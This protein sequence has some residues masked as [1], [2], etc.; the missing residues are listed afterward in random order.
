MR[1]KLLKI[2]RKLPIRVR[3]SI[4]LIWISVFFWLPVVTA[5]V[6]GAVDFFY[7]AKAQLKEGYSILLDVAKGA[8]Q[9]IKTGEELGS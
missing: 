2:M 4:A 1:E 5:F 3:A 9:C 8:Y 6:A 7:T